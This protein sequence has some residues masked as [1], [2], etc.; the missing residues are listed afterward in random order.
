MGPQTDICLANFFNVRV[1]DETGK[2]TISYDL[3][4]VVTFK[5]QDRSSLHGFCKAPLSFTPHEPER[6]ITI[7]LVQ[8][9]QQLQHTTTEPIITFPTDYAFRCAVRILHRLGVEQTSVDITD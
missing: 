6:A 4:P 1:Q 8:Q 2:L 3:G 5:P 7:Q 9:L